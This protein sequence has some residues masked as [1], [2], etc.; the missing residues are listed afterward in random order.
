MIDSGDYREIIKVAEWSEGWVPMGIR[1][2][3]ENFVED[4]IL[5]PLRTSRARPIR[6]LMS[7]EFRKKYLQ[8]YKGRE[9]YLPTVKITFGGMTTEK[10]LEP[11]EAIE[12]FENDQPVYLKSIIPGAHSL[13]GVRYIP[14]EWGLF[15]HIGVLLPLCGLMAQ[16]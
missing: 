10:W 6:D 15:D 11:E 2:C 14:G 4:N 3:G 16:P 1:L 12:R 13:P 5:K 9:I 7:S 8:K